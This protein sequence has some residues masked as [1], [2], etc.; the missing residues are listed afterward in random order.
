MKLEEMRHEIST[1]PDFKDENTKLQRFLEQRGHTCIMLPKFHCEFNPIERCWG[2]AKRYSRTHT[3]YTLTK[4]RK[5][6]PEAM[7]S[8]I[9]E[10]IQNY[11]RKAKHYMFGYQEGHKAGS[12]IEKLI[13]TVYKSHRRV[14]LGM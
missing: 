14:T 6:I 13:K 8:I 2:H 3:N 4:L 7:D 12:G 5:I 11:F 9:S 1:H 10:T